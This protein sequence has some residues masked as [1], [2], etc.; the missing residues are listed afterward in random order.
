M[1]VVPIED[2]PSNLVPME[3]LPTELS[4]IVPESDLPSNVMEMGMKQKPETTLENWALFKKQSG[5][6]SGLEAPLYAAG[7]IIPSTAKVGVDVA[8]AIAP[9]NLKDTVQGSI[10]ALSGYMQKALPESFNKWSQERYQQGAQDFINKAKDFKLQ[11]EKFRAEGDANT[12]NRF[13]A[14]AEDASKNAFEM[15][16]K[17]ATQIGTAD[18]LNTHYK[19]KYGSWEKAKQAF[20]EDPASVLLDASTILRGGAGATALTGKAIGKTSA[21]SKISESL[22]KVAQL[23]EK[24][25]MKSFQGFETGLKGVGELTVDMLDWIGP[26]AGRDAIKEAWKAGR[27]KTIEFLDNMRNEANI[28]DVVV[29]YKDMLNEMKIQ[30][31]NAY[32]EAAKELG[33]DTKALSWV[34]LDKAMENFYNQVNYKG[35]QKSPQL[36]KIYN[37]I[38]ELVKAYKEKGLNTAIDLDNLKQSIYTTIESLPFEA[39]EARTLSGRIPRVIG[40]TIRKEAPIYDNMMADYSKQKKLIGEIEQSLGKGNRASADTILRK[41]QSTMRNNVNT[42]YGKRIQL[43]NEL[44]KQT[45]KSIKPA[46]AGQQLS[47]WIPR[48]IKSQLGSVLPI[49]AGATGLGV[50]PAI[51]IGLSQSP[52]LIGETLYGLGRASKLL[53]K[54]SLGVTGKYAKGYKG[55]LETPAA[56]NL[57]TNIENINPEDIPTIDVGSQQFPIR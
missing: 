53:D 42:N 20:A 55:I 38:N 7:N 22:T 21:T 47:S 2:L 24:P 15:T 30:K 52:R 40:E 43:L 4:N 28:D 6:Y 27:N 33:E 31:N 49:A 45:N 8:S 12:A 56:A 35:I 14:L 26:R 13:D 44:E 46:L 36:T 25:M 51:G 17:Y 50:I 3:D 19:E 48:G 39:K 5:E 57:I 16:N 18:A 41:L 32:K 10:N 29:T 1:A 11:A 54:A 9:W 23:A 34:D 37:D